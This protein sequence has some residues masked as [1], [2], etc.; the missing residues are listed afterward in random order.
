MPS[1]IKQVNALVTIDD[2]PQGS[3]ITNSAN[4]L[5]FDSAW[6]TELDYDEEHFDNDKYE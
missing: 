1:I 4:R 2:I 5:I 3:K 6:I